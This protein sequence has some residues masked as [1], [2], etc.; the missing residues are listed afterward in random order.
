[1]EIKVGD[2]E[3]E[4][5]LTSGNSSTVL[6]PGNEAKVRFPSYA[7]IRLVSIKGRVNPAAPGNVTTIWV[8]D[9]DHCGKA[10]NCFSYPSSAAPIINDQSDQIN[11]ALCKSEGCVR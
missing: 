2:L 8:I 4:F 9:D 5:S 11:T 6:V 10:I 7:L 3:L 1:M